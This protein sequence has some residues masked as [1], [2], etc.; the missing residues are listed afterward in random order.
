MRQSLIKALNRKLMGTIMA[1][2]TIDVLVE[3]LRDN[4]QELREALSYV[5]VNPD[6]GELAD[7]LEDK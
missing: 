4:R 5:Y 6:I 1:G 2:Q 3:W 7:L